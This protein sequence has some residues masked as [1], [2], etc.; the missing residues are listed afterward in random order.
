MKL[1][2]GNLAF[3]VRDKT[4]RETFEKFGE[5]EEATVV[6]DRYSNDRS[7]G[8]GFV[9]FKDDEAAKAAIAEMDGKELEGRPLKV[10]ESKPR[11]DSDRPRRSFNGGSR[12][13]RSFGGNSRGRSFGGNSRGGSRDG[14]SR[15]RSFGGNTRGRSF[16]GN[17]NRNSSGGRSGGRSSYNRD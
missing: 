2:V 7:K 10:N 1:Y 9:T 12:G 8:F 4:L 13:G 16:G 11:D 5:I 17:S 3:S 14:D 6:M 15:G